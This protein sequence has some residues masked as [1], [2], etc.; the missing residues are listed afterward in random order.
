MIFGILT[1][2]F[3]FLLLGFPRELP[4][5]REMREEQIKNGNIRKATKAGKPTL[6]M[7]LPELKDILTN[8]TFLFNT[9]AQVTVMWYYGAMLPFY[10]KILLLKFGVTS[11]QIGYVLGAALTPSMGGKCSHRVTLVSTYMTSIIAI[12]L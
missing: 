6:K 9:L 10:P 11:E 8:W 2:V 5:A 12:K 4:G 7:L 1:S 3:S